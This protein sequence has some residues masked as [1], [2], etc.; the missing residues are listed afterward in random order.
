MVP[1]LGAFPQCAGK[2]PARDLRSSCMRYGV[3]PGVLFV[4]SFY[5]SFKRRETMA[6]ASTPVALLSGARIL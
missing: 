3:L 1:T 2:E 6:I 5:S 4:S